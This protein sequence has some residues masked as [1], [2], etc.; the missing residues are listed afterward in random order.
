MQSSG[1]SGS[2]NCVSCG[3][4]IAFDANVCQYCG[5]DYRILM[6]GPVAGP[7]KESSMPEIGGVLILI[8]ALVL[9]VLAGL[10]IIFLIP[11]AIIAILGGVFAIQR[12][13]FTLALIGGIFS[14]PSI[15]GIV[16]LILVVMSKDE[17]S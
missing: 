2:R 8:G 9:I 13:H 17:F 15:I 10:C 16:G 3:R 6:A 12:K 14:I 11:L 7:K 1:G 4:S 5:Y